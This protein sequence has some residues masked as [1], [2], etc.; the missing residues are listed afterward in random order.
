LE[1]SNRATVS[2]ER[3]KWRLEANV[4]NDFLV[5]AEFLRFGAE[6][7]PDFGVGLPCTGLFLARGG[8]QNPSTGRLRSQPDSGRGIHVQ[9]LPHRANVRAANP[10]A[11][12]R[13]PGP[14]SGGGGHPA[15]RS[16]GAA[17]RRT[18]LVR[19]ERYA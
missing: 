12:N 10:A 7:A 8:W 14:R 16:Q 1:L 2:L 11:G 4:A 6:R 9:S 3:M 18:G 13:L 19:H 5:A 17:N 15:K